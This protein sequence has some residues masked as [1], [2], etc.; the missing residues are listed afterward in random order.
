[1][2]I[3]LRASLLGDIV[4]NPYNYFKKPQDISDLPQ[5]QKGVK[6]EPISY[7]LFTQLNPNVVFEK[8]QAK[9][10]IIDDDIQ[11]TGTPDII[12]QDAVIDIKNSIQPDAKLKANYLYQLTAY[13]YLFKKE[14]AYLFVD[15]NKDEE[16]DL[17]KCR[18]IEV[19][20]KEQLQDFENLLKGIK[21][22]IDE[23]NE[24]NFSLT[25]EP[26]NNDK[27]ELITTY[28]QIIKELS[29]LEQQKKDIESKLL[30][31]PYENSDYSIHWEAKRITKTKI[32]KTW[33]PDYVLEL[34]IKKQGA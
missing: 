12:T 32:I 5:V 20:V 18:L 21:K 29:I 23:L 22:A 2:I 3:N 8:Q 14:K 1:M 28:K 4:A 7:E 27:D 6:R 24:H 19:D 30:T 26:S 13:C 34:K 15:T 17:S 9:L 25:L 31:T 11:L 33:T 16:R 10:I